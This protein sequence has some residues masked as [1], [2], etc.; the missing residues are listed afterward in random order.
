MI[1]SDLIGEK[2][3]II[4]KEN[5]IL[6]FEYKGQ[7]WSGS[8][9]PYNSEYVVINEAWNIDPN[10]ESAKNF[11]ILTTTKPFSYEEDFEENHCKYEDAILNAFLSKISRLDKE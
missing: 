11:S 3:K 1:L 9:N 6:P 8:W 2:V 5:N 7:I 4:L 10:N